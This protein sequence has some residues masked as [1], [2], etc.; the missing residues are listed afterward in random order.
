MQNSKKLNNR[1]AFS[2]LELVIS[3]LIVSLIGLIS[4]PRSTHCSPDRDYRKSCCQQIEVLLSA[5]EMYNMDN[6]LPI[7]YISND[8][9]LASSSILIKGGYLKSKLIL[10]QGE[11]GYFVSED[12]TKGGIIFCRHHGSI[13]SRIED[14]KRLKAE[15]FSFWKMLHDWFN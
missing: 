12:L 5:I 8:T 4:I 1:V 2:F 15:D 9:Y 7:K 14:N 6:P 3:L 10:P 13:E 11:C